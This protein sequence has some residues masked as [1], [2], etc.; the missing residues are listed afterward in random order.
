MLALPGL[1]PFAT[2]VDEA[3]PAYYK[4]G[5]HFDEAVF[6]LSRARFVRAVRAEGVAFDAGF[7]AVH[8]GRSAGRFRRGGDLPEA[9]RAHRGCVALHHP[10][11]LATAAEVAEVAR[12]VR[13]VYLNADRL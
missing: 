1:R 4:V 9:E 5:F 12:A 6:G 13:K 3:Q 11:L 2:A 8:V 7:R 10:V